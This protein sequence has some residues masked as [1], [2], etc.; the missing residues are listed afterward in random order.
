MTEE[1]VTARRNTFQ[2]CRYS[3]RTQGHRKGSVTDWLHTF[4][5]RP[6]P[7]LVIDRCDWHVITAVHGKTDFA[8]VNTLFLGCDGT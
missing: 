5:L 3:Q 4:V 8:F 6:K 1:R 7:G 2:I